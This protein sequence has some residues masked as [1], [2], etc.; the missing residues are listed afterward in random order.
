ME[1]PQTEIGT[2]P[3]LK[4]MNH[5]NVNEDNLNRVAKAIMVKHSLGYEAACA[6]LEKMRLR[7]ICDSS[8]THSAA[9][10]AALLTAVN[11]GK[12]AFHGGV[13][14]S[15]PQHVKCLL[16]WPSLQPLNSIVHMMGGRFVIPREDA[17]TQTVYF[18]SAPSPV[19]DSIFVFCSGWRGGIAPAHVPISITSSTDFA[20]GGVLAGGLA[21]ANGFLRISGL[22]SRSLDGP[23]GFSLWRPDLN[24][25]DADADGP[26]LESLPKALWMLGLGHLGQAYLWNFGLIPYVKPPEA[27]FMLQD[28]DVVVPGNYSSQLLCEKNSIGRKKTRVCSEWLQARG[29][30][31]TITERPFDETTRRTG[32]E[33]FVACC[34]F[35]SAK[36]RRLIEA[37]G[38]DLIV[39]CALGA[40]AARFDRIIMHT[41][42]DASRKPSDIWANDHEPTLDQRLI[43]AFRTKDDCGILAETLARKSISSSFVGAVAGAFV[44]GEILRSLNGGVRC[45]LIQAHLRHNGEPGV[46]LKNESYG[47]RAARSGFCQ[48]ALSIMT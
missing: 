23:Q 8:V 25:L 33:P 11:T 22:S 24:W 47:L 34:G 21:V 46:I 7:L 12:R 20:T 10:Q 5:M 6:M 16:P 3:N 48:T 13:F 26:A 17:F 45:E 19:A 29:F 27:M 28:F 14:V 39:E 36:P 15:M 44:T 41:F 9:M 43:E 32:D 18:G 1:E 31:T 35:D 4:S 38:F 40:D 37:A 30:E 2:V 42:P